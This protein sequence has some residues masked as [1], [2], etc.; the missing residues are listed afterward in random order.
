MSYVQRLHLRPNT[1]RVLGTEDIQEDLGGHLHF[2]A[3]VAGF[4]GSLCAEMGT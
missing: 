4:D 1:M 2:E 3:H